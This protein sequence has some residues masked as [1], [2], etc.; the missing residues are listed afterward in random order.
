VWTRKHGGL[1][2]IEIGLAGLILALVFVP[3]LGLVQTGVKGTSESL[4]LSRAFQAAR[5]AVDA[6]E[7]FGYE[8]LDQAS[9]QALLDKLPPAP[10]GV[11]R[12]Q[13]VAFEQVDE[14]ARSGELVRAK[15]ATVKVA[16][17]KVEGKAGKTELTLR[18]MV[19]KAR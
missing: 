17:E 14:P 13:L 3:T 7:S 8:A 2:L 9:A 15:I 18:A 1:T 12:P 11:S 6:I 5:A 19:V 16:W 10:E 4:H